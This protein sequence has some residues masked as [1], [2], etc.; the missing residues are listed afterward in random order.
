MEAAGK[1]ERGGEGEG[2][3]GDGG[4]CLRLVPKCTRAGHE[5]VQSY[6]LH[7]CNH[8]CRSRAH[9]GPSGITDI[10][11][12]VSI[13]PHLHLCLHVCIHIYIYIHVYLYL[14]VS[15]CVYIYMH[16]IIL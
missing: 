4:G 1:M 14:H 3:G 6:P 16:Y 5:H 2:R 10:Y 15:M 11:I 7:R 9:T 8:F 13:Y 12:Y